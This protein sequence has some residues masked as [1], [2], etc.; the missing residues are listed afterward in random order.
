MARQLVLLACALVAIPARGQDADEAPS[1]PADAPAPPDGPARDSSDDEADDSGPQDEPDVEEEAVDSESRAPEGE[2]ATPPREHAHPHEHAP[3]EHHHP[4]DHPHEHD[5]ELGVTAVV[6]VPAEAPAASA[7]ALTLELG[8]LRDVP[9][10]SAEDMLT[11]APGLLV[12]NHA[13]EGHAPTVFLRGFD[14]GEGQDVEI[15]VDGIPINEPSNAHGHGYADPRF[16]IP[17]LVR[18]LRVAPGAF[19]PRQG[20]FAIAGS[21]DYRLGVERRGILARGEYG[22][23]DT[24]RLVLA[25]APERASEGTF[26]GVEL[27][28]GQGFGPNRA[29]FGAAALGRF[30]H[31]VDRSLSIFLLGAAQSAQFDSAGVVR[32][33]DVDSGRLACTGEAFFCVA[34]PNQ[35]GSGSRYLAAVGLRWTRPLERFET[36]VWAGLR[37]LR[38]RENFTG[39]L[40]D[41]RGDGLDERYEAGTLGLRGAYRVRLPWD[42][43]DHHVEVG[44]FARHDAGETVTH[45]IRRERG[46]PYATVFDASLNVTNLGAW[47]AGDFSPA[48]WLRVSGGVRADAFAFAVTDRDRP[49]MDRTGPRLAEESTDAFGLALQPR[50]AVSVRLHESLTW[51]TSAGVGTRSSDARAL[52]EGERAPFAR[53]IGLESGLALA[54][55]EARV[56]SLRAHAGVFHTYVDRELVFDAERGR[57]VPAGASNRYGAFAFARLAYEDWLD[58]S[59]SVAWTEA[60]LAEDAGWFDL[61]AGDRL[62]YVPRVM[63][64]ADIAVRPRFRVGGEPCSAGVA[65][66]LTWLGPRPLPNGTEGGAFAVLD[67]SAHVAWRFVEIGVLFTNLLDVRYER[68]SFA[69]VSRFDASRPASLT[70]AEHFVAGAPFT[71]FLTL[72]LHLTPLAWLEGEPE[73][74]T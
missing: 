67:A 72:T 73:P 6:D 25:W 55:S 47:I 34:D 51:T 65:A 11:L 49:T 16:L 9:R 31:R 28:D 14:A 26:V 44:Y 18:G 3:H 62:P 5:D 53:A 68:A 74:P 8:L 13:G 23:F 57:N 20:D 35:G 48:A 17:E 27:R 38:V 30:E 32:R 33:D 58:A 15:L 64:R 61:T 19:D 52:S 36:S 39:Q 70:P 29:H 41:P 69:Y 59:A 22:A 71:F 42:G 12:A 4:H 10:R 50:G 43:R 54:L 37:Q 45:R 7:G 2:G 60:N 21:I 24:R 63:G 56:V 40:L 66:G 1:R 46:V